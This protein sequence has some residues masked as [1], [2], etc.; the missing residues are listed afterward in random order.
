MLDDLPSPEKALSRL[1]RLG[2]L[3]AID[4]FG[5]DYSWP[6]KAS[7]PARVEA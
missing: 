1:K 6:P 2:L 7:T 5:P 3:L 4:D